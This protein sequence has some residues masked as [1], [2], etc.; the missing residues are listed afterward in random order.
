MLEHT[1]GKTSRWFPY[2]ATMPQDQ[3]FFCEWDEDYINE[4]QDTVLKQVTDEYRIDV[5]MQWDLLKELFLKNLEMFT[6]L[7]KAGGDKLFKKYYC[8]VCT[9]CY[10]YYLNYTFMA[11]VADMFN[12]DHNNDAGL[13]LVNKELHTNPL[14]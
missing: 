7:I 12:H 2:I 1:K 9:R 4:C 3:E 6:P 13:I 8:L 10:G 14:K 5:N 11:P